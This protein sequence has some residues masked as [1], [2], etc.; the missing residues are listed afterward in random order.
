MSQF[1]RPAIALMN[2]LRYAQ[3]FLLIS[4]LFIVPLALVMALL[5]A[6]VN[7]KA[8]FAQKEQA[9]TEYLRGMRRVLDDALHE[10]SMAHVYINGDLGRAAEFQRAQ[11]Q[12]DDDLA[13]LG[14]LDSRL[15]ASLKSSELFSALSAD[16]RE[17]KSKLPHINTRTSDDLHAALI[18]DIR[19]LIGQVGN[20]SNLI[21]DP[22]LDSYYAMDAV[23]LKLPENQDLLAKTRMLGERII[24]QQRFAS[25]DK[26]QLTILSGLLRSNISAIA[27]GMDV[28]FANNPAGNMQPALSAAL[29][30]IITTNQTLL[31]QINREMIYAPTIATQLEAYRASSDAALQRSFTFWDRAVS[32]LDEL[33]QTRIND[34]NQKKNLVLIVTTLVLALVLYLWV[35]FYVAV[36]RTVAG[37]DVAAQRMI[38]GDMSLAVQLDSRDELGDVARS[39][40]SVASALI[41][42]SAYRQA[43]VDNAVDGI[44]I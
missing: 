29:Q 24:S 14:V 10:Q 41:S 42:S 26:A 44:I 30:D 1:L 36:R 12:L 7:T 5:I 37:L 40:N 15:G 20:T 11:T 38:H 35:A 8:D 9:G 31:E 34:A 3:K 17:L 32:T 2:R 39:F 25:D 13:A 21:L 18:A 23:L 4:L 27:Q 19:G 33:L 6:E 43:V 22:D 28:A 16:W